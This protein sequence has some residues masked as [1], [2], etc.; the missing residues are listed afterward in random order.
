[1]TRSWPPCVRS[2]ERSPPAF[3]AR[4]LLFNNDK[5]DGLG[6]PLPAGR[7][8]LFTMRDGKPFLLGEGAM[9]DRAE[10]EKIE[11]AIDQPSGVL[12]SQRQLGT[13]RGRKMAEVVV[14]NTQPAPAKVEVV[15]LPGLELEA[16][17]ARL[18]SRDGG[19]VW[20][21]DLAPG[22]QRTL[23]YRWIPNS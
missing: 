1:M 10:G 19:K 7:L 17:G 11:L 23:R 13:S 6:L 16:R 15:F 4:L 5:A 14:R 18:V 22:G 8:S 3:A 21:V 9:S 2:G 12:V 20:I